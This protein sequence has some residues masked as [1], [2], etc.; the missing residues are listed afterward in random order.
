MEGYHC[1]KG[2]QENI[3]L[4]L[5]AVMRQAWSE[6][7]LFF[8]TI[9]PNLCYPVQSG[10]RGK[11]TW[12][13]IKADPKSLIHPKFLLKVKLE[14]PT[15][16]SLQNISAY[17]NHWAFKAK[18]GDSFSFSLEE[19]SDEGKVSDKGEASDKDE[20]SDNGEGNDGSGRSDD[21]DRG[22]GKDDSDKG[23]GEQEH[24]P[25]LDHYKID[26]D[27]SYPFMCPA[28][29]RTDCLQKLVSN[30]G[31]VNKSFQALVKMVDTFEVS[32]MLST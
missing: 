10:R 13:E 31:Q 23:D 8:T 17:W 6:Y 22:E 20:V 14:N 18:K 27:I 21:S 24:V 5:R 19:V 26:Q 11:V 3:E 1:C 4:A 30:R 9:S 16:M 32:L 2:Q 28:S 7:I 25:S 15:R 12:G 29:E